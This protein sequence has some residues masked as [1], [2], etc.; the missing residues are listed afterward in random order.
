MK[1]IAFEGIDG[2]GLSTQSKLIFESL[3]KKGN[4]VL[5]T[6]EPTSGE[7]GKIIRK[8]LKGEIFIDKVTLSLLFAADRMDHISKIDFN[9][10]DYVI[11][12]RY[13][14]SN[15]AYQSLDVDLNFIMNI[16]KFALKPHIVIF[17]DVPTE[18]CIE[19]IKK[20]AKINNSHL[21]IYEDVEK[22]R[23]IRE[24]F[25]KIFEKFQDLEIFIVDGKK[26]I[27]QV[28]EEIMKIVDK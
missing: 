8:A 12:D 16:N 18:I 9:K 28:H 1:F 27:E 4:K 11:T 24:N 22:L 15:L 5:L 21:E 23:R 2:S 20:R 7:I 10:Y 17:L 25:L 26:E 14:F 19:R 6:K 13:F 3:T